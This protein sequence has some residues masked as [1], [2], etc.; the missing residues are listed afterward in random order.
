MAPLLLHKGALPR[1]SRLDAR[2]LL[3]GE[4]DPLP[5]LGVS[6]NQLAGLPRIDVCRTRLIVCYGR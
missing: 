4:F 3:L 5:A 6:E 2:L 1:A